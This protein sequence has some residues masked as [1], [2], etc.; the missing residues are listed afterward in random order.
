MAAG[1]DHG[2]GG[3][4]LPKV[5]PRS[6][7]SPP[8]GG[9][10]WWSSMWVWPSIP[11]FTPR[12][13]NRRVTAASADLSVGPAMTRAQT[14]AA[15]DVGAEMASRLVREGNRCLIGGD[16]G[17]GN[18][19]PSAALIASLTGGDPRLLT[20]RGHR[21]RRRHLGTQGHDRRRC[22]GSHRGEVAPGGVGGVRW[23]GDSGAGPG[24]SSEV[25]PT[26]C[27]WSWTE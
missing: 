19:T 25:P 22:G 5:G 21:H 1:G 4:P 2:D 9:W 16:M 14:L 18:T 15:L 13:M 24:S 20:G 7:P 10:M 27:R 26:G 6:T 12:V 23:I 3:R 11:S 17:I 8:R